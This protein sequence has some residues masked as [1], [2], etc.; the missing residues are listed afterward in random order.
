MINLRTLCLLHLV[1]LS[2]PA[3]S[4]VSADACGPLGN[5]FGPF[6][7]RSDHQ[8]SNAVV[9]ADLPYVE[10][11]RLVEGAHFTPR[12]ETLIGAQSGGQIGPPGGDL[13]YTLRA[14]PNHHRALMAV[15]RYGE[16]TKS[17]KPVGLGWVV[18]CYFERAARFKP[19]DT[20]VKMLY[21]TYLIKHNRVPEAA[22]QLERATV[23]AKDGAFTHYNIGLVYF[24]MKNY[25]KA[26]AQAHEAMALGFP[27]TELRDLLKGVNQWQEPKIEVKDEAP[28]QPASQSAAQSG[29]EAAP[30]EPKAKQ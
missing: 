27:R 11:R 20:I 10:R 9:G 13:D 28:V 12:V 26:L 14:F 21:A 15:M 6:D 7:Y 18:E 17:E 22:S 23:L 5:G 30:V 19:D 3:L 8:S 4:Q 29:G 2:F 1:L 16:K 24:D 25:G